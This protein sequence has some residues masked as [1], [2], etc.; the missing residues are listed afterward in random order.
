[1]EIQE[2]KS[3]LSAVLEH[4]GIPP[5]INSRIHCPFHKD[6]T[7]SMQV[8]LKT[9]SVYCFSSNCKTHG[10]ALDVID[11]ILHKENISKAEA[12]KKAQTLITP[13]CL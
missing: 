1:M 5:A 13:S 9:N 3:R 12:I 2:I 7:P 4:Y 6:K 10:K 11:F 8:Y